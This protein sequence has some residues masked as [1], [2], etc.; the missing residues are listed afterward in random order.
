MGIMALGLRYSPALFALLCVRFCLFK[1]AFITLN[2]RYIK[3][4]VY[5][6]VL[7]CLVHNFISLITLN[8]KLWGCLIM[9]QLSK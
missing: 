2:Y 7:Q 6:C 1:C 8:L 3:H 4:N 5:I 9:M